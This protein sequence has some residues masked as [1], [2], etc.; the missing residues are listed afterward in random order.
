M[1]YIGLIF[2]KVNRSDLAYMSL[3]YKYFTNFLL[4]WR[5]LIACKVWTEHL[6]RGCED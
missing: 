6:Y 1:L 2:K 3:L 4:D 5:R